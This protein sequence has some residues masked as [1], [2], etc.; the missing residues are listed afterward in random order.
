MKKIL[1][2]IIG[3]LAISTHTKAQNDSPDCTDL[4]TNMDSVSYALG[5]AIGESL[6]VNLSISDSTGLNYEIIKIA[7][8][9]SI[10]GDSV[11][12][13]DMKVREIMGNFEKAQLAS[14]DAE[15]QKKEA[16]MQKKNSPAIEAAEKL[17]AEFLA[18]NKTIRGVK[19]T[20]SG[21]QYKILKKGKG[22]KP[23]VDQKVKVHYTGK[24][25]DGKIFDSSVERGEPAV[26]GVNQ[27]I[28]GWMEVL[29]LMP[30]GSKWEVYIPSALAYGSQGNSGIPGGSLLIFE[31][32]LLGIEK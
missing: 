11:L 15:M 10:S 2:I 5:K 30:V 17:G 23:K 22:K 13:D 19:T 3:Y 7:M 18:K 16:E 26:F 9:R 1:L 21:L 8:Q 4:K 31:V 25:M 14:R 28:P 12:M 32:E 20:A 29:Q 6:K 24:F 27:V